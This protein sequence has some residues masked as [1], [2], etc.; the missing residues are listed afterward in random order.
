MDDPSLDNER[1]S[2]A[3]PAHSIK[4]PE[5]MHNM[6]AFFFWAAWACITERPG[7]N[8]T[9]TNNW[10]PDQVIGNTPST[11]IVLWTGF[12]VIMLLIGI[13]LLAYYAW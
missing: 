10:P 3:I 1:A 8:I 4:D 5:R 13:G 6:N 11:G 2:Y 12:S 7:S 9:Y